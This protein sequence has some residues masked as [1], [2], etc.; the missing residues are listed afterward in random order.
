MKHMKDDKVCLLGSTHRCVPQAFT[1]LICNSR[2]ARPDNTAGIRTQR[3]GFNRHEQNVYFLPIL[4]VDSGPPSLSS[5][6]T[7]TIHVCGC[8]TG[9]SYARKLFYAAS[10]A[11][12]ILRC[13][14]VCHTE[15]AIQSCNATAYVMS[16]AL[17]P[18]ALIALLVCMLI[19]IGELVNICMTDGHVY[20]NKHGSLLWLFG[21]DRRLPQDEHQ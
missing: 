9:E 12:V 2:S 16:A 17:S 6:G 7:L 3:S 13:F 14:S 8:D 19:L 4:V 20:T 18:G 15:G 1:R 10:D 11:S 5:T 21:D